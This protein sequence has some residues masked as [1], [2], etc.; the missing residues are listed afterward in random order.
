MAPAFARGRIAIGM[1]G[2]VA[3]RIPG[4]SGKLSSG[5]VNRTAT[6]VGGENV[7]D[8]YRTSDG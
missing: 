1:I 7:S 6:T 2:D 4:G 3:K 5:N 8:S